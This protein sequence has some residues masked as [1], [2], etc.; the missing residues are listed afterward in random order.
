[1]VVRC[2]KT[3]RQRT[4]GTD[5][6][7]IYRLSHNGNPWIVSVFIEI[8]FVSEYAFWIVLAAYIVLAGSR[9]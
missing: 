9:F 3:M 6:F 8:P 2:M 7:R 5:A 4:G 1:M